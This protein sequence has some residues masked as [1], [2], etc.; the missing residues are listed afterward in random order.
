MRADLVADLRAL[1]NVSTPAEIGVEELPAS[2]RERYVGRNGNWLLRVFGKDCLWEFEPLQRFV[3]EVKSVDP[4]AA[5]KPFST[6]EGLLGMQQGFLRAALYALFAVILV[7]FADF[8]D[9]RHTAVA[10][11][12]LAIGV[13][14][15]LGIMGILGLALNPANM[16]AFPLILGVGVDNGVHVLHDYLARPRDGRPYR[17]GLSTGRGI[18]VA[19]LTTILG[20]GSLMI[21]QHRGLVGLGLLLTLGVGCCMLAALVFLPAV[22]RILS[23]RRERSETVRPSSSRKAA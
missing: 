6:L 20:F 13:L 2:L 12:P 7:L 14:M 21:S 4:Q 22:L 3:D 17:L 18:L 19:A 16:I 11:L 5:G 23:Q 9:W 8:R 1:R 15:T 10:L